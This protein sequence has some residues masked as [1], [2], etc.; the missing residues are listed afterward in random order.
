MAYLLA[1]LLF[2]TSSFAKDDW[3][4][5]SVGAKNSCK[6]K[7]KKKEFV[8]LTDFD[9]DGALDI[10]RLQENKKTHRMRVAVWMNGSAE[11]L[12]LREDDGSLGLSYLTL[13]LP[14]ERAA[15]SAGKKIKY[16]IS[17]PSIAYGKC[18]SP[19]FIFQWDKARGKFTSAVVAD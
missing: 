15:V 13:A 9:G 3:H 2:T 1:L 14:G 11:P 7:G 8:V 10:A 19:E 5:A 12:V 18:G 4:S 16:K 17:L 6:V